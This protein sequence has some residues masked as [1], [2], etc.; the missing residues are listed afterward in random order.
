MEEIVE[1][2]SEEEDMEKDS[3]EWF[4]ISDESGRNDPYSDT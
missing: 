4:V 1:E 2:I 3:H